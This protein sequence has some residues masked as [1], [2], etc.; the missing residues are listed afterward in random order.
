MMFYAMPKIPDCDCEASRRHR[1]TLYAHNPH[2]VCAV[3]PDGIDTESCLDFRPDPNIEEQQQ[4]SPEGYSWYGDE[5]I[6]NRASRYTT[7]EQMEI[8]DNHPFFTLCVS[9]NADMSLI[10]II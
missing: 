8:L 3:H 5:L 1:C 7:Q 6:A 9:L 2:L 10:E 4:W